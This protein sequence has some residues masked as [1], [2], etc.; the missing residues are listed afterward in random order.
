MPCVPS[1]TQGSPHT[2]PF[3]LSFISLLL[4]SLAHSSSAQVPPFGP[5]AGIR[6][7]SLP[8]YS[9]RHCNYVGSFCQTDASD[10]DFQFNFVSGVNKQSGSYSFQSVGFPE[11]YIGI[12]N[13]TSGALGI[14]DPTTSPTGADDVS[15]SLVSP[16]VPPSPPTT[17]SV[18]SLVT[19]SKLPQWAGKYMVFSSQRNAPCVWSAPAGD[20]VLAAL[21]GANATF[22]IGAAPPSPPVAITVDLGTVVN[23]SVSK[24]IMGC[25]HDYGFEQAP[26]GFS[27]NLIYGS[28][29]EDGTQAVPG[30]T[31]YSRNSTDPVP[32]YVDSTSFSGKPSM[33][34]SISH[35]GGENGLKNRGIGGAGLYLEGGKPYT[36][37]LFMWTG[38]SPTAFVELYDFTTNTSLARADFAVQSAG[39]DWGSLWMQYNF[40]LTPTIGTTCVGIPFGSDPSIDCGGEAGPAHVC[41]RCGGEFRLGISS[42]AD[43]KVGYVELMPGAWGLLPNKYGGSIPILKSAGDVLKSMGVTLM[44]NGGS[45]SQSMRWKDWRGPVWNRPSQRQVWGKSLLSGFG[46]FEYIEMAEALDLE[47]IITLAYDR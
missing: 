20:A 39:P 17:P 29:F 14:F 11:Q 9:F 33:A 24:R 5:I 4:L 30:W 16:L 45:V 8:T 15:W 22:M 36:V 10:E 32:A 6:P 21:G 27:A 47:P 34:F 7:L 42:P 37:S 44:R 3:S 41:V 31:P 23:P 18:F 2:G 1:H 46:P 19:Q 43:F 25:H 35:A 13:A 12:V 26:R 38:N 28:S 40:T